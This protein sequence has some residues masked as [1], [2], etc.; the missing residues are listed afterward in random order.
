ML[1]G[2]PAPPLVPPPVQSGSPRIPVEQVL[3]G[4]EAL[5]LEFWDELVGPVDVSLEELCVGV[6]SLE[7]C[8]ELLGEDVW[9]LLR[10]GV[11]VEW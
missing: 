8:D 10:V 6:S 11:V 3:E 5:L 7:E 2:P 4:V 1:V 9:L